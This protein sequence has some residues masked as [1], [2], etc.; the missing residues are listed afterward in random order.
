MSEPY[1]ASTR[2][3]RHARHA[4]AMHTA[5]AEHRAGL[6][7]RADLADCA[8]LTGLAG[9]PGEPGELVARWLD[10]PLGPMLAV[11]GDEGLALLEFVDRRALTTQIA[12]LRRRF[13]RTVVPESTARPHAILERLA[14][15]LGDYFAGR[16][17]RFTL[18]L[19]TPGTPFQE[20]V[21]AELRAIAPGQT[22][23]YA[24]IA[25]AIGRPSATRAVARANGDN[26]VAIIIPCHR[27]IGA[28]GS[29]TGYGGGLWRKQRLL[30][31]E[32]A[33]D[34]PGLFERG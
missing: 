3:A 34:H 31:L 15:E 1:V 2:I 11:A 23:S 33:P 25:R 16:L 21:W 6:T 13:G 19:L 30:E 12:V 29:L 18:P 17:T 4:P 10:T 9:A 28:D 22:R 8:V 20:Q 26:R 32:R 27:V 14:A 24:Q 5:Q 7:D